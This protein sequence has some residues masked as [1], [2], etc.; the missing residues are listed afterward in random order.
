[1]LDEGNG[2]E[3]D[4]LHIR[5]AVVTN[6]LK[7]RTRAVKARATEGQIVSANSLDE[8]IT[9]LRFIL[10]YSFA[11]GVGVKRVNTFLW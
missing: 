7:A 6:D 4:V 8:L 5:Y 2:M 1:M 10:A 3:A 9:T 11:N